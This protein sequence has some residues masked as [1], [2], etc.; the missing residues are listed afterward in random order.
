MHKRILRYFLFTRLQGYPEDM[1]SQQNG[2]PPHYS[3]EVKEHLD[4]K[5]PNRSMGRGVPIEW[6]SRSLDLIPSDYF[7]WDYI[8]DKVC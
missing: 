4:R 2:A 3:L 6:P 1:I 5:P 8:K 7:L